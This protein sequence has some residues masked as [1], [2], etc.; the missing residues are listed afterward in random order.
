MWPRGHA[1]LS[2]YPFQKL[3]FNE[4]YFLPAGKLGNM[5]L[6]K[7]VYDRE[8]QIDLGVLEPG[9]YFVEASADG[10]VSISEF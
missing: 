10:I 4:K 3:I 8:G 1:L 2:F 5:V 6:S 9:L 7:V